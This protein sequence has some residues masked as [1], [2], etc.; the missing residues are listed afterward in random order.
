MLAFKEAKKKLADQAFK[1][2]VLLINNPEI[3]W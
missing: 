2:S 1:L 3:L